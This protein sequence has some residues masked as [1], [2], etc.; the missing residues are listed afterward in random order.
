M[1]GFKSRVLVALG[2][3]LG[4][5]ACQSSEV[6][7]TQV[8][9]IDPAAPG[10]MTLGDGGYRLPAM[11]NP[12]ASPELLMMLAFSG[13]GKRSSAFSYGVLRGLRDM[14]IRTAAG[15]H[16]MLDEIDGIASVSGGSFTAASTTVP[17]SSMR[18]AVVAIAANSCCRL[19]QYSRPRRSVPLRPSRESASSLP[20][21]SVNSLPRRVTTVSFP[22]AP[23]RSTVPAGS[24]SPTVS[25]RPA[26]AFAGCCT[27]TTASS[28]WSTCFASTGRGPTAPGAADGLDPVPTATT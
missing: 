9:V 14:P 11:N 17:S 22:P 15:Q 3:A 19:R 24:R 2:L 18:P 26:V 25:A 28:C 20:A 16:R 8:A 7:R 6:Y 5:S 12:E 10:H 23:V 1:S 21:P 13:G 27:A 4:A